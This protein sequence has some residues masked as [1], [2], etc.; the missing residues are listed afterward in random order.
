MD[1]Y[2]GRLALFKK[3]VHSCL[4]LCPLFILSFGNSSNKHYYYG[5]F[6]R[7][8]PSVH[9]LKRRSALTLLSASI[10]FASGVAVPSFVY[11]EVSSV[12]VRYYDVPAGALAQALNTFAAMSGVYLGG[13]AELL[14]G[15]RTLGFKGEYST[16]QA[17][18]LLLLG[19]GLSYVRGKGNSVVLIDPNAVST[20]ENGITMSPLLVEGQQ[21]RTEAGVQTIGLDEIEAMPTEGGNLTDLLR[22]NTAVNYSRDS[23]DSGSSASLR[24][25]EISIH[26]QDYYQNAFMIDGIDTSSDFDP[27]SSGS[28]DTYNDPIGPTNLSTLSGGSPQSYYIDADAIGEVRVYDSNIPVEY[29]GFMGGVIDAKLKRYDGE[30]SV[31]IKYGL[32]KDTWEKFH[33]DESVDDGFDYGDTYDGSYTPEYKKQNYSVT[34]IKG[35][36]DKVSSTVTASRKTSRFLQYYTSLSDDQRNTVYYDDTVDNIMGRVDIKASEKL[37]LGFSLK[38]S[39]RYYTGITSTSFTSP[40]TRTHEAYG[41]SSDAN[42]HFDNSKLTVTAGFDRSMDTLDSDYS[43]YSSYLPLQKGENTYFEGGYGDITQQQDRLSLS[44]KW[45]HDAIQFGETDHRFT[46][47]GFNPYQCFLQCGWGYNR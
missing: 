35:W 47:G 8:T 7:F 10:A 19:T 17:L 13:S 4:F 15:K 18:D 26:G 29:G 33:I 45:A 32:S 23:S 16:T 44:T 2:H 41:M 28:G 39:N 42:Y 36:N 1:E 34:A 37:D 40:F 25:D 31:F 9:V 11:A 20:D 24:P 6:M 5:I 22:T 46:V 38:Y 27:G 3:N 12:S 14:S 30:D 21:N 43:T